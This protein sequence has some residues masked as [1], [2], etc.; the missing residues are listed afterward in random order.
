MTTVEDTR[1]LWKSTAPLRSPPPLARDATC[2]V[3]VVGAGIAGLST[4]YALSLDGARVLVLDKGPVG[5]G[6]TAQTTAHLSSALDDR[7]TA[8]ERMHGEEGARL[9]RDSHQA[10]IEWIAAAVQREGAECQF[11]RV[12]GYLAPAPGTSRGE[13]EEELAAAR[14]AGHRGAELLE[15]APQP[16]PD[17]PC[18]R[19]PGLA[20]FHP[21]RYLAALARA[22][23]QAGGG[24]HSA[25][26]VADVRGG[27][28]C[29]VETESGHRVRAAA[30][31][32][33]TNSPIHSRFGWHTKQAPFRTYV[34]AARIPDGSLP[35]LLYW[36]T[37]DPYR[38]VRLHAEPGRG[39]F[40]IVG[41]E[42]HKTGQEE[43]PEASFLR[44]ESWARERFPAMGE[45]ELRWSGQVLEPADGLAF[46]GRH[47]GEENL[48]LATG[49]SGH[50]MT[51]GTLAGM[52][53]S[54][55]VAG[56]ENRWSGLYDPARRPTHPLAAAEYLHE[57]LNVA[58]QYADW[59]RRLGHSLPEAGAGTVIRDGREPLAVYRDPDGELHVRSAVCTHLGCIVQWNRVEGSWDCPCHGSRFAPDGEVLSGPAISGLRTVGGEAQG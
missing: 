8:L 3:C 5:G 31:V 39:T 4:A 57:N 14:R 11:E 45:V 15:R 2:D 41:G 9:A 50:G 55:L 43:H 40:L 24:I 47:P 20:Q 29:L 36:D 51:H 17:T 12:D 48:Y 32:V 52:I 28:P 34:V 53:I 42:D 26:A 10:A 54:D 18:L 21:L 38:Y 16:L 37:A 44:L 58:A 49:D 7:F 56:R 25:T 6:E 59:I 27:D 35:H 23:E 33:A 46:I 19:F 1:S 30:V 13:L 22:V